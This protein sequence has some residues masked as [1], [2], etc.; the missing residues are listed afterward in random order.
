MSSKIIKIV[1]EDGSSFDYKEKPIDHFGS[2]E[3]E[4]TKYKFFNQHKH[5][6]EKALSYFNLDIEDYAKDLFDLIDSDEKNDIS[7]FDDED[8]L[9]EVESRCLL[10]EAVELEN[11][12]ILNEGFVDRFVNIINRGDNSE[13]ENALA[14]LEFKYK[15]S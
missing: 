9:M 12:N 5:W 10:P 6:E 15:I 13:I 2:K 14:F 3:V 4:S 11:S 8:I 1:M 7:D